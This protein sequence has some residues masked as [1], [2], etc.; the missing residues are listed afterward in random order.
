MFSHAEGVC[1]HVEVRR[2]VRV[3]VFGG[4]GGWVMD[5]CS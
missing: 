1:V 3:C 2:G 4:V 5:L